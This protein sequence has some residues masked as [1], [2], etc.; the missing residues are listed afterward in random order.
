MS[1][2]TKD[3]GDYCLSHIR[4]NEL[5]I[6]PESHDTGF[7]EYISMKT[8]GVY[9][10]LSTR[11]R[12][13][14]CHLELSFPKPGAKP[15]EFASF[16]DA[17]FHFAKDRRFQ[18]LLAID[19]TPYISKYNSEEFGS[20]VTY[21]KEDMV[22]VTV[23]FVV[24]TDSFQKAKG[25]SEKLMAEMDAVTLYLPLPTKERLMSYIKENM[26]GIKDFEERREEILVA[27]AGSGFE[28]VEGIR[29][30]LRNKTS[31]PEKKGRKERVASFG[32]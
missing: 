15:V 13:N 23:L 19:V 2:L 29:K 1:K 17:P 18:G 5:V 30:A 24:S 21:L 27:I 9:N 6:I 26:Q 4:D 10:T 28:V 11:K 16:Y 25:I 20:L 14:E 3:V 22:D 8:E 7:D 32:Y 12:L 31:V